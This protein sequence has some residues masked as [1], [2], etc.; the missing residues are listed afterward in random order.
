MQ[1][2]LNSQA[3]VPRHVALAQI[4]AVSERRIA[5]RV[6]PAAERAIRQGHP[7]LFDQSITR[8]SHLGQLG[9]LAVIFDQKQRFLAIGLYDPFAPLRVRVLQQGQAV[10]IDEA[11]FRGRLETAVARRAPLGRTQT[12]GYRLVHGENDQLPGLVLDRYADTL[13][14]RLDTAAW[15]PHLN[16]L[17]SVLCDL[18]APQRVVLRLSRTV[19]EIEPRL[20]GLRDGLVLVGEPLA[21]RVIFLENGLRFEA[22]V[23]QGQKTGFFLDQRENRVRVEQLAQG[24][25]VLNVFAYSGGFSLYAA[26]GGAK[27]VASLDISQPALAAAE[28]NFG[29]NEGVAGVNTA[30]HELLLGDAFAVLSQLA[31]QRRR[32]DLVILDPP[33]FARKQEEVTGAVAAYARLIRL[34]LGVLRAEGVLVTSSC[35]SRVTAEMFFAAVFAAAVAEK[36]PLRELERTFHPLDHPIRFPEG[37]YLKTLFAVA[38]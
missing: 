23:Q 32:F 16:G 3:D 4:P 7:W 14:L 28:R 22:D 34:G 13:V 11:W 25:R 27:E 10:T 12:T 38:P 9:D 2:Q 37:A 18:L 31:R 5:L 35:S 24:K 17:L 15:L 1:F 20:Y 30:V 36:R 26:R 8:Q 21:E 29:L 19:Q 33:S 6:T